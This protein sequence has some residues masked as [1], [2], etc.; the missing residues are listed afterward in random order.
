MIIKF[1]Q[2]RKLEVQNLKI[3]TVNGQNI[4]VD[5]EMLNSLVNKARREY[6]QGNSEIMSNKD[7]DTAY[8]KLSDL[9]EKSGYIAKDSATRN[10]GYE[11]V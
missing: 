4:L 6:E 5:Q 11:V 9:E 10:V 1:M 8:D 7:Y 2:D 3:V